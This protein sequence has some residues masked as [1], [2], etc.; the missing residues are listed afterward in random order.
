MKRTALKRGKP[1]RKK[2]TA[3]KHDQELDLLVKQILIRDRGEFCEKCGSTKMVQASHILPKGTYKRLRFMALNLLLLCW[4]CHFHFWHKN[5][6]EAT[7]WL[8]KYWPGR[9]NELYLWARQ[10]PAVDFK[11]MKIALELELGG[12]GAE[13]RN[14]SHVG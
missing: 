13:T 11:Q 7:Q 14:D 3:R 2:T 8:E 9:I 4:H 5:P 1:P 10:A 12:R 6:V